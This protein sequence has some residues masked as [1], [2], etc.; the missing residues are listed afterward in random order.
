MNESLHPKEPK[1]VL[2]KSAV[3]CTFA[4]F[5]DKRNR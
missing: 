1:M 5:I 2:Y 3:D 4:K